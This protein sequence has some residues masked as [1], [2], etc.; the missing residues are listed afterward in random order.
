MKRIWKQAIK[1]WCE[2]RRDRLSLSLA[3]LLPLL[4]LLLFGYGVRMQSHD[5]PVLVQDHS[6]SSISRALIERLQG[7]NFFSPIMYS[8][9]ADVDHALASGSAKAAIV[10]PQSFSNDLYLR[11]KANLEVMVDGTDIINARFIEATINAVTYRLIEDYA[12]GSLNLPVKDVQRIWFN[13]GLKEAFFIVPG[14]YGVVLWM[15][16]SLL[17]CVATAREKDQGTIV[18]A[19]VSRMRAHE[20][21][22]GKGLVYLLIGLCEALLILVLGFLLFGITFKGDPGVFLVSLPLLL[23]CSVL[24]GI[25][26]GTWSTSQTT[27]VQAVS[28]LGFFTC[29]LLS[30]F[31]YP[32]S[33]IPFP[34]SLVSYLVPA[35]YFIIVSRDAFERGIG[36][37]A[38]WT[39]PLVLLVFCIVLML[40]SWFGWRQMQYKE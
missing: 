3:F 37:A 39:N 2:F 9:G 31:V 33:N 32:I 30:G 29:L 35:R 4:T 6:K 8:L 10:I 13:P 1:D 7:S 25:A 26:V 16:P 12:P 19:F 5:I 11:R 23:A 38:V 22:A 24:F 27:A 40:I 17:S 14:A 21:I 28:S 36:W 18:Q 20:L 34:L 15:F